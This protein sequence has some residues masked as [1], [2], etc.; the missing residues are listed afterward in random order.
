MNQFQDKLQHT[1]Q[2]NWES[3][4]RLVH[5]QHTTQ[6]LQYVKSSYY[7]TSTS[8]A[9]NERGLLIRSSSHLAFTLG[10]SIT[11]VFLPAPT[12]LFSS[13]CPSN[14]VQR[15]PQSCIWVNPTTSKPST[16]TP[17][18]T[19]MY[20]SKMVISS[21]GKWNECV[22]GH[23]LSTNAVIYAWSRSI[24]GTRSS[25]FNPASTI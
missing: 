5:K 7:C 20:C 18:I 11:I 24:F 22:S 14:S 3:L 6:H 23:H 10:P 8:M 21:W 13:L 15:S 12:Y 2:H 17:I 19:S 25:A 1:T 4:A 16:R 9:S